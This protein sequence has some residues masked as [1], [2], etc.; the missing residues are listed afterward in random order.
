VAQATK[1]GEIFLLDRRTGVPIYDTPELPVPQDQ[2]GRAH[3]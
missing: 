2:I 3:V 1:R